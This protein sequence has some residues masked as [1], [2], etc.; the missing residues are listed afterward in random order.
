MTGELAFAAMGGD[1]AE[2]EAA[3]LLIAVS[4]PLHPAN[5]NVS[6]P[7]PIAKAA[8]VLFILCVDRPLT[9]TITVETA[10]AVPA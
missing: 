4:L 7:K 6:K 9:F 10:F 2:E 1:G 8:I 3:E 5:R